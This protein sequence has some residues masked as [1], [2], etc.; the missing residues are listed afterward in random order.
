M[1]HITLNG[2]GP[3]DRHLDHKIIKRS[4]PHA[5]QE[6][7]LCPALDLKNA[8]TVCLAE[9]VIDDRILG[10]ESGKTVFH[11]VV[12]GDQVKGFADAREHTQSQH[13]DL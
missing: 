9:H 5:R 6:I 12:Q 13:I 4:W 7:H 1:D 10:R 8:Q 11:T 2:A 3:D